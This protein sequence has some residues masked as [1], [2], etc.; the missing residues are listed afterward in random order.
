MFN[1]YFQKKRDVNLCHLFWLKSLFTPPESHQSSL[2]VP[3]LV[4]LW[5]CDACSPKIRHCCR[6]SGFRTHCADDLMSVCSWCKWK[7]RS[8]GRKTR[9]LF[10]VPSADTFLHSFMGHISLLFLKIEKWSFGA[11]SPHW[12]SKDFKS[13]AAFWGNT[14]GKQKRSVVPSKRWK[15]ERVC[16]FDPER[17]CERR[18]CFRWPAACR[19]RVSPRED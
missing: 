12:T 2:F 11:K 1:G 10:I 18:Q 6:A 8:V 16:R 19:R 9:W 5:T 4:S 3:V 15:L 14:H 17:L 7:N 13:S